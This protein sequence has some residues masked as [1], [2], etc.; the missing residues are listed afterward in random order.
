[1]ASY[2]ED[3]EVDEV[4]EQ[5]GD[6]EESQEETYI[7][8]LTREVASE[9]IYRIIEYSDDPETPEELS[10]NASIRQFLV[11][12]VR[13]KLQESFENQLK[14]TELADLMPIMKKWTLVTSN[15]DELEAS[16]AMKRI[17]KDNALI[18][19]AVEQDLE[20]MME[21]EDDE[22]N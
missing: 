16:T 1:M 14:W 7:E 12:K 20:D 2:A 18:N 8:T 21:S 6:E 3:S 11:Q 22:E 9:Q 17:I 13:D 10:K 4:V 15:D 19:E 5:S